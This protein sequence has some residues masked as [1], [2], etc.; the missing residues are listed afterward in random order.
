MMRVLFFLFILIILYSCTEGN[1]KTSVEKNKV[2]QPPKT[3]KE[4]SIK[5]IGELRFRMGYVIEGKTLSLNQLKKIGEDKRTYYYAGKPDTVLLKTFQDLGLVN[6]DELILRKFNSCKIYD[7]DHRKALFT[8][9][10]S[11]QKELAVELCY[12]GGYHQFGLCVADGQ[13]TAE[14]EI[15]G[16]YFEGLKYMLLDIIE[17]G[18]KE[19]VILNN[20]YIMNGDNSDLFIYQINHN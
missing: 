15:D 16:W 1:K 10:D 8:L 7:Y 17:G 19:L 13:Q 2:L 18:Y 4:I 9:S 20:Y 14:I 6:N 3:Q 5:K 11:L 12:K